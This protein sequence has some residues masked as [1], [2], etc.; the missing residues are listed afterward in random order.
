MSNML[1]YDEQ[2]I[3]LLSQHWLFCQL[4]LFILVLLWEGQLHDHGDKDWKND[5]PNAS[6]LPTLPSQDS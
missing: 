2:I 3:F 4:K 1:Q 5:Q 6:F